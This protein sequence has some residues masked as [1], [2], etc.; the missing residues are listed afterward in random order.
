MATL[1][2]LDRN[3]LLLTDFFFLLIYD[4]AFLWIFFPFNT[5]FTMVIHGLMKYAVQDLLLFYFVIFAKFCKCY[6]GIKATYTYT[7]QGNVF[8]YTYELMYSFYSRLVRLISCQTQGIFLYLWMAFL[9]NGSCKGFR[10]EKR[11]EFCYLFLHR[12]ST[13]QAISLVSDKVVL[14]GQH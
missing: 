3:L 14:C 2:F 9:V 11:E 1:D 4:L 13:L 10:R 5:A 7:L 12:H 8:T 6:G